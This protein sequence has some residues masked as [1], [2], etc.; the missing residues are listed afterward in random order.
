MF[1]PILRDSLIHSVKEIYS[2]EQQQIRV[3]S[4]LS[5]AATDRD[6]RRL[7]R[8]HLNETRQHTARLERVFTLLDEPI[9]WA[10][11]PGVLGILEECHG[12]MEDHGEGPVRDAGIVATAQRLDYYEMAAYGAAAGWAKALHLPQVAE[13]LNS[14]LDEEVATADDLLTLAIGGVQAAAVQVTRQPAS[15]DPP[16]PAWA[17]RGLMMQVDIPMPHDPAPHGP[18]PDLPKSPEQPVVP[19]DDPNRPDVDREP[20]IDPPSLEPPMKAPSEKPL[21]EEPPRPRA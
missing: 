6:L 20:S 11:C 8:R 18:I 16:A 15:A 5:H 7:L 4:S 2:A 10:R 12:A 14:S 3:L 1:E 21:I 9:R 19:P 17:V 13:L